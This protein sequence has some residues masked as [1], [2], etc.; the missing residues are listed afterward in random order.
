M[1]GTEEGAMN[2]RIELEEI[3]AQLM[4]EGIRLRLEQRGQRLGLRGSLPNRDGSM[5]LVELEIE[6]HHKDTPIENENEETERSYTTTH[7]I[8]NN[9]LV[10]KIIIK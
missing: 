1:V 8:L 9:F 4:A 6:L 3:N 7:T 10:T 5:G 2:Q